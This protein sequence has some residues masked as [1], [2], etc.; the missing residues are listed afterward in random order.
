M[1][2]I[3]TTVLLLV[4][5]SRSHA[6]EFQTIT[7]GT[8][9]S[10]LVEIL[11]SDEA[12]FIN[13]VALHFTNAQECWKQRIIPKQ[14]AID[15][16]TIGTILVC[17]RFWPQQPEKLCQFFTMIISESG[18]N[19][20]GN[21]I[22]PSF[23]VC[24]VTFSSAHHACWAWGIIHPK[25]RLCDARCRGLIYKSPI[26]FLDLLSQD[27][28]FNITCGAGEAALADIKANHDWVR[29]VLMYKF[30]ERGFFNALNRLE[31][32][33]ITEMKSKNG[34]YIWKNYNR[35][36]SWMMCLNDRSSIV[37]TSPC[38]CLPIEIITP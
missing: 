25:T 38:G 8:L 34:Q 35:V 20:I 1:K 10:T 28:M 30:G 2:W 27:V 13:T 33:P 9:S 7:G 16:I 15:K 5:S 24:H 37:P 29:A 14:K 36:Y 3:L 12:R 21:P 23:G 32:Q 17:R 19:N 22:D 4:M 26:S 31:D 11:T 18:G 6:L